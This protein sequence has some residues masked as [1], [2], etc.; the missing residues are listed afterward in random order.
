MA[1]VRNTPKKRKPT[2]PVL[3]R[4]YI[5]GKIE[6]VKARLLAHVSKKGA[7]TSAEELDAML[8][9]EFALPTK[10]KG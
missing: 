2:D 1:I 3:L 10:S 5:L 9:K 6:G 7:V 8:A 4:L